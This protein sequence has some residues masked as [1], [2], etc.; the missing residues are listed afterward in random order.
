ML[1]EGQV[2]TTQ[3]TSCMGTAEMKQEEN[4]SKRIVRNIEEKNVSKNNNSQTRPNY[5]STDLT[6][7]PS[8]AK[9]IK[10]SKYDQ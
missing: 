9:E 1:Y 6:L 5:S 3:E 2:H 4:H 8:G 10:W 7:M